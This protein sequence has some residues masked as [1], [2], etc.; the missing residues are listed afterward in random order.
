MLAKYEAYL[1]ILSGRLY[2]FLRIYFNK[3]AIFK[4][5]YLLSKQ[6]LNN[7]LDIKSLKFIYSNN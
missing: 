1:I 3:A 6:L 5:M 4:L 2:E 7:F